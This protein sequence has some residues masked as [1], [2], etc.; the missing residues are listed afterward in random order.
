MARR[1]RPQQT[2]TPPTVVG[3]TWEAGLQ[4]PFLGLRD[5]RV[6]HPPATFNEIE[7]EVDQRLQQLRAQMLADLAWASHATVLNAGPRPAC[8]ACGGALHDAGGH[9]RTFHTLGHRTVTLHRDY[10]R[11]PACGYSFP[12]PG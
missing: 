9:Q 5:W 8:P 2:P 6:R 4:E 7:A 12:P 1:G 11:C 10:A 3:E